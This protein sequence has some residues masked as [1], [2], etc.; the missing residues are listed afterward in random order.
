MYGLLGD[1]AEALA[2]L[3]R[4]LKLPASSPNDLRVNLWLSS[5]WDDPKF[6]ALIND[7]ANNA[8]LSFDMKYG[9][10]SEN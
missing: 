8:P 5:L 6:L 4:Q 1:R 10:Q 9:L 7:P 2:E 3:E